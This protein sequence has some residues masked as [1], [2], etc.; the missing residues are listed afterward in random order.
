MDSLID[1]VKDWP[2][3]LQG[4][5]G[6][7][8][9]WLILLLM[10]KLF[11]FL[12]EKYSRYSKNSRLYW[13]VSEQFKFHGYLCED[14]HEKNYWVSALIYRSFRCLIKALMWLSMGLICQSFF[15]PLGVIGFVG[16]L[17]YLFRAY[18]LVAP[19]GKEA[20]KERL[21]EIEREIEEI[22]N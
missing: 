22:E 3:I 6:S 12:S 5:L 4:A 16:A 7:A 9:F 19:I 11:V 17:F 15:S 18:D 2:V 20:T 21:E 10:N 13:L 14:I 1:A 8:L